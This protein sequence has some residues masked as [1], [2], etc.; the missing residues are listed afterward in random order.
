MS[1]TTV[2]FIPVV[3]V[4]IVQIAVVLVNGFTSLFL[5][6]WLVHGIVCFLNFTLG[7]CEGYITPQTKVM[8]ELLVEAQIQLVSRTL[9][10]TEVGN[11]SITTEVRRNGTVRAINQNVRTLLTEV[12]ERTGNQTTQESEID[13]D[14]G[15]L[16]CF[17]MQ[18][19]ITYL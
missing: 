6:F 11:R 4:T 12:V 14:V 3:V 9:Y 2:E 1:S 19:G 7:V 18:V 17:P 16:G 5:I 8:C 10:F 15:L 13:S